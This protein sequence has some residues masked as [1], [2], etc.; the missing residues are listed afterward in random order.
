[1]AVIIEK[2]ATISEAQRALG[3]D[4]VYLGGGTILMRD[5]NAGVIQG[6]V[7][8]STDPALTQVRPVGDGF[9]IG[10]SVTMSAI[11]HH[12]ELARLVGDQI[13]SGG[14]NAIRSHLA[15]RAR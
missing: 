2:H 10:A 7:I 12:A 6:R 5:I 1:M 3:S 11:A 15:E 14:F 13:Y 9:E 8:R 4:A